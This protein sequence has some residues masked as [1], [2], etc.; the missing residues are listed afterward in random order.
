MRPIFLI[1]LSTLSFSALAED[2]PDAPPPKLE[3]L[4]EPPEP[5]MPVQSGENMEPD[6]T[7]IRKGKQTI[8]EYRQGGRLY[9]IKVIPEIGPAY[10]VRDRNHDGRIDVNDID[11]DTNINLWKLLEW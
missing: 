10:Y 9:L 8:E 6:I 7:I 1:L 11:K 3:A 4:P 2:A 5:P